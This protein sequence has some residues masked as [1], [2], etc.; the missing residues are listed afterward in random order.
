MLAMTQRLAPSTEVRRSPRQADAL[1]RPSA[2]RTGLSGTLINPKFI[3]ILALAS[4]TAHIISDART[5]LRDGTVQHAN[6]RPPQPQ[7]LY[8]TGLI[9][10]PGRVQTRLKE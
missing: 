4:G 5:A 1:N 10:E 3:L 2:A 8:G 7:R 9:A 6:Q